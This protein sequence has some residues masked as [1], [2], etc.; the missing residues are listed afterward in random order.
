VGQ[1]DR[2]ARAFVDVAQ[3]PTVDLGHLLFTLKLPPI[4]HASPLLT[5]GTAGLAADRHWS[6][7][8]DDI[9]G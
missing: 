9:Q 2:I 3:E 5:L 8:R 1:H 4:H 7:I 6:A